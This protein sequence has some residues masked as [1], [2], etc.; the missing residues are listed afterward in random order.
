MKKRTKTLNSEFVF[1]VIIEQQH[2]KYVSTTRSI[3]HLIYT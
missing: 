3:D 1:Y 2:N